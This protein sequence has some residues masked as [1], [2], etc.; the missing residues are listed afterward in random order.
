MLFATLRRARARERILEGDCDLARGLRW[1]A[2]QE[3]AVELTAPTIT[4]PE[5]VLHLST[6]PEARGTLGLLVLEGMLCREV[7]VGSERSAEV[8]GAGD[9]IRPW[10]DRER[11]D[12]LRG[13]VEWCVLDEVRVAVLDPT[14]ARSLARW[15]EVGAE[16]MERGLRRVR[17][18]SALA[19]TSHVKRVDVRVLALL[20]H[21]ADRWGRVTPRG[22]VLR[23]ALTHAR[24]A[25]I[26]GAQR[27]SVTTA[28]RRLSERDLV[29]RDED[30]GEYLLAPQEVELELERLCFSERSRRLRMVHRIA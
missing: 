27:P 18:G 26:V 5:G 24:I 1:E 19:A 21:L 8:V 23:V 4:L 2:A 22:I 25:S 29:E 10:E 9:V 11:D 3:A 28:L 6:A 20:W 12:P 30:T 7:T 16:L 14:F 15:P 13:R 17:A